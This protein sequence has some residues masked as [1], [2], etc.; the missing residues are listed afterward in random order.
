M[1]EDNV[2]TIV[3]AIIGLLAA[4]VAVTIYIRVKSNKNNNKSSIKNNIVGG[5]VAG[6][7]MKKKS[8]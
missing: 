8:K 7:D 6:R 3:L 2:T 5:D 4:G 1:S